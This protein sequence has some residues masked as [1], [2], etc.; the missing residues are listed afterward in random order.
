MKNG[1][2]SDVVKVNV[3]VF[4]LVSTNHMTRKHGLLFANNNATDQSAH[5]RRLVSG[6]IVRN[7]ANAIYLLAEAKDEDSSQSL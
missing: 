2:V 4:V 7:I 3:L 1:F 6:I 5:L